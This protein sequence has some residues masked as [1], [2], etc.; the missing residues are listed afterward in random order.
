MDFL[1]GKFPGRRPLCRCGDAHLSNP[2][3]MSVDVRRAA[4]MAPP[5][6][7]DACVKLMLQRKSPSLVIVIVRMILFL[8]FLDSFGCFFLHRNGAGAGMAQ[9]VPSLHIPAQ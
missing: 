1:A 8:L 5:T 9:G 7:L 2:E 3:I 4:T 6:R